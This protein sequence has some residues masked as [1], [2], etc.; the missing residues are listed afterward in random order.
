MAVQSRQE[1]TDALS[2]SVEALRALAA[3]G[4]LAVAGGSSTAAL[5][6]FAHA[7]VAACGA[8]A[9]VVRLLDEDGATLTARAVH[10][11]SPA[12]A[13][14]LEGSRIAL[15]DLQAGGAPLLARTLHLDHAVLTTLEVGGVLRGSLEVFRSGL[16]FLES[17]R[18]LAQV[19]ADQLALALRGLGVDLALGGAPPDHSLVL[20]G[21]A[22]A[23][24]AD[25]MRTI[26]QVARLAAGAAGAEASLL[27]RAVDGDLELAASY[28]ESDAAQSAALSAARV[29][30][31]AKEFLLQARIGGAALA[32]V[33]LGDP[34]VGV[35]QL[36][37]KEEPGAVALDGLATF[38]LRAAHAL[39]IGLRART[40]AL[41]LERTRTLLSV[42]AQAT[43]QL[44][45]AHT[46]SI[47]INETA[48]LL[49]VARVAVYLRDESGRL[50]AAADREL[51]GPHSLVA[52]TLL[53]M[54]LGPYRGR[55]IVV[56]EDVARE[57]ALLGVRGA[58]SE[59]G[60][61]SA[62]GLP[63]AIRGEV[64]GLLAVYPEL[65]RGATENEQALLSALAS[66]LAV[67]VQNALLHE[68]AKQL[69]T[70]LESALSSE[71]Q[72]A[73]RIRALYEVS[74]SFAQS[75]SLE[76]TLEALARNAV[77][78][79]DV[80]AAAIR[81]PDQRRELLTTRAL[82]VADA[83]L[84]KAARTILMRPQPFAALAIQRLFRTREPL[85]LDP[86]LAREL[87]GS[88]E[89]LAPF[90]EKGSTA[91]IL[92]IA[93]PAE[94]VA[95]LTAVSFDPGRPIDDETLETALS[96]AAQAALAI[97]NGRLYQQQK[98][99]ADTMQRSLLPRSHPVLHGL[100]IGE[101]YESSARVDV[102][103]DVY[104]FME[105]NDGRLAV[106]LGDVTG[107]G[108]DATADM[109][110]AKFVFRSLARE[111]PDP[112][113]FLGATNE[114]VVGEIAPGKFI[115]MTYFTIDPATGNVVAASAGH[116]APLLVSADGEVRVLQCGGLAL[117]V[118]SHQVY[119]EDS[120][121][122]EP[123]DAVVVFTDGVVEAR[124]DGELYGHDR[125]AEVLKASRALPPEAVARTVV[126]ACR[127][128]AG[129]ELGD[130]CAVVVI[131]RH[132]A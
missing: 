25:E 63:L 126:D 12:L 57:P 20:A 28:G 97:D 80:D 88:H 2:V 50:N 78:L 13:A 46:L 83:R 52:E 26:G 89:L 67:A 60:I 39:R 6:A 108:I 92:P 58:A 1:K 81:M 37:F 119:G 102:G 56:V 77:E 47:A 71:R 116:P 36:V 122:L 23:A 120:A 51:A 124:R 62:L 19:A 123:G 91:A 105:L 100:E 104:D 27:W 90:L 22:L 106:V 8:D 14:Q 79:L 107:H 113:D 66:Q 99:F 129:G 82:H 110:M 29:A 70:D 7:A 49:G 34:P 15:G 11:T 68:Q 121:R 125:L 64:I 43:A 30:L 87:G 17:E 94:V 93:T 117:G 130:D 21:E 24:G 95:T 111:H 109:A 44:S 33:R 35:L 86:A 18:L 98:E 103:G 55:G 132:A 131:K 112:G 4:R 76:A 61:E 127:A 96:I 5:Q 118:D 48:E 40:S 72:A 31:D 32:S 114:V 101:V 3:A 75:L 41:E 84:E 73:R 115:T 65:R 74:R 54:L 85:V 42:A 10:A 45:L 128:F 16:P 69:G 9:G 38:A 59:A 53:G